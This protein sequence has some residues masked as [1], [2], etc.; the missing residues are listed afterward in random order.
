MP[1]RSSRHFAPGAN[2]RLQSVNPVEVG[3]DLLRRAN[4]LMAEARLNHLR[5]APDE[6]EQEAREAL[7]SYWSAMNWLEDSAD[8]EVAH[9]KL[10]DAGRSVMQTY[11]CRYT[12]TD[13]GQYEQRCPVSLAH[14]RFGSS[15]EM[16]VGGVLCSICR[17]DPAGC[18]HIAGRHYTVICEKAPECTVCLEEE[19]AHVPGETYEAD[20]GRII[21]E[22]KRVEGIAMVA[23]PAT[24]DARI[25]GRPLDAEYVRSSQPLGWQ[26]GEPA[27]CTECSEMC[28]GFRDMPG[29]R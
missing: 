9:I 29:A 15:P 27:R 3:R 24:P 2:G 16:V 21:T 28:E 23:R 8:F 13:A 10:H 26:W 6:G 11:G 1:P 25:L 12:R 17:Q 5:G 18:E 7:S 19:C 20:C 22:I 14:L 4:R